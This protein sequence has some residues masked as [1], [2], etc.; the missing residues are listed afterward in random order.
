MQLAN[1]TATNV[2][3]IKKYTEMQKYKIGAEA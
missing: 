2:T 3:R 1:A